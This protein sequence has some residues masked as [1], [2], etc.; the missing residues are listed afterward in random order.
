MKKNPSKKVIDLFC[1]PGGLSLGF[2]NAGF[3]IAT[4]NHKNSAR[5]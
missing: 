5:L 1:G 2:E 3:E 4:R